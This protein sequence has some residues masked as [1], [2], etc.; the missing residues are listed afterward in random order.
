MVIEKALKNIVDHLSTEDSYHATALVNWG[1]NLA[2]MIGQLEKSKG[3]R[4]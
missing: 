3:E 2:S 4:V 1:Y